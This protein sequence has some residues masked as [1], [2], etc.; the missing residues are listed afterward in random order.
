MI[1]TCE[2]LYN[3]TENPKINDITLDLLREY[4]ETYLCPYIFKYEIKDGTNTREIEL[5]FDEENFCHLLG[6][7]SIVR[8]NVRDIFRYKGQKGWDEIKSG[9][10]DISELKGRN[11]SG[12]KDNKARFVFFYLLPKLV[13]APQGIL[14]DPQKLSG[15]TR[16]ECELLFFDRF[17]KAYIHIGIEYDETKDCYIP[18][19]FL[20]EKI[21][22][23]NDGMK[24]IESQTQISVKKIHKNEI[25]VL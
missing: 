15:N 22:K 20:I 11:K 18:R 19:T 23:H 2:E 1:K 25:E 21:T 6:L 4:Y 24:Y 14:F 12:F 17:K 8:R 5:R 7:E 9:N 3:A 13:D 16:I 10:I